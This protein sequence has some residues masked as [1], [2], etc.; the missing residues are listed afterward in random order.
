MLLDIGLGIFAAIIV[1]SLTGIH[2]DAMTMFVPIL[3]VL[4]PDLDFLLYLVKRKPDE[5]SH[6]HRNLLHNPLLFIPIGSIAIFFFI[7]LNFTYLFLLCSFAHFIHD[8]IG[9]GWGIRWLYPFSKKYYKFFSDKQGKLS[10]N[11]VVSWTPEEQSRAAAE[12]GDPNWLS[13]YLNF[14]TDLIVEALVF[15]AAVLSLLF[16]W[17]GR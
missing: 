3:F 13:N 4:I 16:F 7:G 2:I 1:A 10:S 17:R 14:S 8:S 5:F 11:L 15:V 9:T 12:F 6:E